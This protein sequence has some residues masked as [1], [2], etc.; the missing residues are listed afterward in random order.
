[1]L[2]EK[3]R[4]GERKENRVGEGTDMEAGEEEWGEEVCVCMCC[5]TV[6]MC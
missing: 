5:E 1:M 2:R 3:R 4:G 6:R